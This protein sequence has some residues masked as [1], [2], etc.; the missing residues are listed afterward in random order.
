MD[1][2]S[3]SLTAVVATLAAGAAVALKDT[4]A[5]AVKDAYAGLKALVKRKYASVDLAPVERMPQSEVKRASLEEDLANAGAGSDAELLA[6]AKALA[7]VLAKE[8]PQVA[9]AIGVDLEKVKAAFLRVGAV[10]SEGTGV[11]VREGEFPEGIELGTV[12]AGRGRGTGRALGSGDG[13][14]VRLRL[15]CRSGIHGRSDSRS[16]DH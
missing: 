6:L 8:A 15:P 7:D 2:V 13:A 4:A 9:P 16:A 11:K 12:R 3:P 10:E 5:S 1:P 14:S